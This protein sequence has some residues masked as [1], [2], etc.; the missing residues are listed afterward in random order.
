MFCGGT[1]SYQNHEHP[2]PSSLSTLGTRYNRAP[3]YAELDPIM[4]NTLTICCRLFVHF[5][6]ATTIPT[7]AKRTDRDLHIILKHRLL[8]ISFPGGYLNEPLRRT[9]FI[10]LYLRMWNFGN[11]P[12]MRYIVDQLRQSLI[13]GFPFLHATA[14]DLL[15]WILFIGSM[16]SKDCESHSWYVDHLREIA[17]HLGLMEWNTVRSVL[18]EFFFVDQSGYTRWEDIWNEILA[19]S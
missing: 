12:I 6:L 4:K 18:V 19:P 9:L 11:L 16:A 7:L 15:L 3:W 1:K 13:P 17:V 5:H 2:M 8:S 10:Y 14:P